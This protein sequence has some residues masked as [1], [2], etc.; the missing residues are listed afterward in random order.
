MATGNRPR[1]G[2]ARVDDHQSRTGA[3]L[4]G[5]FDNVPDRLDRKTFE[6]ALAFRA[7]VGPAGR[8]LRHALAGSLSTIHF[9]VAY[10]IGAERVLIGQVNTALAGTPADMEALKNQLDTWNN[11]GCP[12]SAKVDH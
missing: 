2:R 12:L 4:E 1:G 8:L 10:P 7:S 3:R 6:E 11:L 9:D 5:V